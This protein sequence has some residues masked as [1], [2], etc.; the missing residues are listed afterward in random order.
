MSNNSPSRQSQGSIE[1]GSE[2]SI[3]L[4]INL[5]A[6][7]KSAPNVFYVQCISIQ[8]FSEGGFHKI[9]ILKIEDGKK[10]VRRVA[11]PVYSQWKTESEVAV[12]KYIRLN[13]NISVPKVYYW[14]SSVNNTVEAEYILMDHLPEQQKYWIPKYEELYKLVSKYFPQDNDKTTFVLMHGDFHSSNIL[15]NDDKITGVIDWECSG[16]FPIEF[17]CTYPV[18]ITNNP[19]IEQTNEKCEENL[20]LQKFFRA[21]MS[22][23]NPE[24]IHIFDNID[25]GKKEFY[26]VVFSQ[27]I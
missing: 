4:N 12:M 2:N 26:S 19:I 6:L 9:F 22:R 20:R 1:S 23:R 16:A 24:F 5:D 15:V 25:E 21:E 13:T 18:W 17:L 11:Y 14:N 3:E 8:E 27:E 10:Y 7:Q